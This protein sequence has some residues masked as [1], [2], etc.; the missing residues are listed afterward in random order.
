MC[1]VRSF[2]CYLKLGTGCIVLALLGLVVAIVVFAI[3]LS[4][5]IGMHNAPS[6]THL[7]IFMVLLF[8]WEMKTWIYLLRGVAQKDPNLVKKSFIM[9]VIG[10]VCSKMIFPVVFFILDI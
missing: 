1:R 6:P 4:A 5:T 10:I 9:D 3:S 7:I 2:F 8:S